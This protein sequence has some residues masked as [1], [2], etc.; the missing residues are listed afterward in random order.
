M[1]IWSII[2]FHDSYP[3]AS[4]GAGEIRGAK[5]N[6]K[7]TIRIFFLTAVKSSQQNH[8]LRRQKQR[9]RVFKHSLHGEEL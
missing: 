4:E 1:C 9:Q 2:A 7:K 6:K 3:A 5:N 8:P